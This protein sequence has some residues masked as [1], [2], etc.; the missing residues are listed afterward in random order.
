MLCSCWNF[1]ENE[2]RAQFCSCLMPFLFF[3]FFFVSRR[4]QS[5][6]QDNRSLDQVRESLRAKGQVNLKN[7][8]RIYVLFL[9]SG[10]SQT[11]EEF[12]QF[13][14]INFPEFSPEQRT[15]LRRSI[16]LDV[17][18]NRQG[19]KLPNASIARTPGLTNLQK[20]STNLLIEF[21]EE[22]VLQIWS[23]AQDLA[24]KA[25]KK[26]VSREIFQEATERVK[27]MP[28]RS[29]SPLVSNSQGCREDSYVVPE[30][31]PVQYPEVQDPS[32]SGVVEDYTSFQSQEY[33]NYSQP[34]SGT[35]NTVSATL[36]I[37]ICNSE[38]EPLSNNNNNNSIADFEVVLVNYLPVLISI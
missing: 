17:L 18:F 30:E 27:S 35:T 21:D 37:N 1:V 29:A 22:K 34:E 13:L 20:K 7:A 31:D 36:P 12:Y 23:V 5:L 6:M 33:W 16:S 15:H 10:R 2:I 26:Q 32:L 24:Q 19:I 38:M 4:V 9:Q 11:N 28:S 3:S 14:L 25:R 8:R